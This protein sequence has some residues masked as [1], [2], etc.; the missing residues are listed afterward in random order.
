VDQSSHPAVELE[1]SEFFR[2][3]SAP[4]LQQL[5]PFVR[6]RRYG[7]HQLLFQEGQPA[8]FLWVLRS[9]EIRILKTA[10]DGSV[11]TLETIR[12]GQIFGAVA[13]LEQ[14]SYPAT[15]EASCDSTVW[16]L[17]RVNLLGV[18]RDEPLLTREILSIVAQRL[19]G[20]HDRLRSFAHDHAD[21]RLARAL[22][23]AA[24][25]GEAHVTRRELADAAGST[26]ETAI[27][28]LKRFEHAGVIEGAV[29]R[30]RVLDRDALERLAG[31]ARARE[32]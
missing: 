3:I 19:R 28:V 9:G 5:R 16:R 10:S 25:E 11:T 23:A 24:P 18:L 12:P 30:I 27:R 20:A 17:S 26:V 22:L 15:A 7:R 21:A 32:R 4:R 8:E 29:G 1:A 2:S 6:E 13:A 31:A 14:R